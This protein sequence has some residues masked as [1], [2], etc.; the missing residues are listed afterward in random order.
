M[1]Q[2]SGLCQQ[3]FLR[4]Y[5][6]AYRYKEKN[7]VDVDTRPKREVQ[8]RQD[9]GR[10]DRVEEMAV[11]SRERQLRLGELNLHQGI[12]VAHARCVA[13]LT[14]ITCSNSHTVTTKRRTG[15][16]GKSRYR[17]Q[18]SRVAGSL[19]SASTRHYYSICINILNRFFNTA[20]S[21]NTI[22]FA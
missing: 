6:T 12:I 3:Q 16:A 2:Q 18:E 9:Y 22:V 15:S 19:A 11:D 1:P 13:H 4:D 20:S 14:C 21:K 8:Q 17:M 7:F 5:S 10:G